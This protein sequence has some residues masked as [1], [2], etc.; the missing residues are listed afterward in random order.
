TTIVE[1]T[2]EKGT[3]AANFSTTDEEGDVVTVG[4][5]PGSNGDGYYAID[6]NTVVL[7]DKGAAF[8]NAGNP[9]PQID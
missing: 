5:K 6:G 1:N 9:L 7:T 4:F 3:V 8:V 2:A